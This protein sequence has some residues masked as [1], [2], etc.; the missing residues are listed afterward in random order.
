[1]FSIH[2]YGSEE[3]K[4]EWLPRM[5]AGT[6]IGCFGLT[7]PISART[8]PA[9]APARRARRRR[10]GARRHQDV[11]HQRQPRRCRNRV[12]TDRRRRCGFPVPTDTK[13][14]H[15][16]QDH[17]QAVAARLDHLRTGARQRTTARLGAAAAGAGPRR[18]AVMP[19]TR[20][21]SASCSAPWAPPGTAWRPPLALTQSREV[22][23]RPLSS[24]QLSQEK[25]AN[26]TSNSARHVARPAP[27][28]IK[29]A[30]GVRPEQVQPGQAQQRP[31]GPGDR[32]RMPNPGAAAVSHWSTPPLRHANNLES[33]LTYEGTSEMHLLSIGKA[34]T[35]HA[36][37]RS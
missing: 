31:R 32:P 1:M 34:L 16:Q 6:A 3:Q 18:P 7:E 35:G 21:G 5:A 26:M 22:F 12:G 9:C 23:D 8:R 14:F 30:E 24:Y 4:N 20:P 28:R 13:G 17:L 10:L 36:A 37:F 29:D 11:D 25:L 2:R 19:G 27:R 15:R 33:V